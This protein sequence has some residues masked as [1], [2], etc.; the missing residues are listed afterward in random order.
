[1]ASVSQ[2]FLVSAQLLHVAFVVD[3]AMGACDLEFGYAPQRVYSADCSPEK[4]ECRSS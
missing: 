2:T 1:M 4:N 3:V